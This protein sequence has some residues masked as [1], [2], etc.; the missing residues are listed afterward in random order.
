MLSCP[1]CALFFLLIIY[2]LFAVGVCGLG[3]FIVLHRTPESLLFDEKLLQ[4]VGYGLLITGVF[5]LLSVIHGCSVACFRGKVLTIFVSFHLCFLTLAVRSMFD[6]RGLSSL[7]R[8]RF[9]HLHSI[10]SEFSV[11]HP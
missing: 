11:I 1:K 9:Y 7:L 5:L 3:V 2:P 10:Q 6:S 8:R 4:I